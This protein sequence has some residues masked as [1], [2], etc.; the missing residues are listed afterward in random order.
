[1]SPMYLI[2]CNKNPR[3]PVGGGEG[4]GLRRECSLPPIFV[5]P[6]PLLRRCQADGLDRKG[7]VRGRSLPVGHLPVV[8]MLIAESVEEADVFRVTVDSHFLR[9]GYSF[10]GK[11]DSVVHQFL[12]VSFLV[13]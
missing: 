2:F 3:L 13:P 4:F 6:S 10:S 11:S 8:A 5:N 7:A 9:L 1:M 12:L